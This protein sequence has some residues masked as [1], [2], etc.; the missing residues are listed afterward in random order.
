MVFKRRLGFRYVLNEDD[1][2]PEWGRLANRYSSSRGNLPLLPTRRHYTPFHAK[3]DRSR[4]YFD[5]FNR[6]TP[7]VRRYG[8]RSLCVF[9]HQRITQSST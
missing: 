5:I 3:T 9:C 7:K 4:R 2:L 6:A 1:F 8:T